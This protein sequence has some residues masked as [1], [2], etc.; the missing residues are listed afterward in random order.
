MN[1]IISF[2]KELG[3]EDGFAEKNSGEFNEHL[4]MIQNLI[5]RNPKL[6]QDLNGIDWLPKE[7]PA[8]KLRD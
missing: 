8:P 3:I 7:K 2:A 1:E 6:S 5:N 4:A